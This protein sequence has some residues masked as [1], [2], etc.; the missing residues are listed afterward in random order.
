MDLFLGCFGDRGQGR[1]REPVI[2]GRGKRVFTLLELLIVIAII[3]VLAAMLLPALSLAREKGRQTVCLGNLRQIGSAC[4]LYEQ[5]FEAYYGHDL[6]MTPEGAVTAFHLVRDFL[7]D[8]GVMQCPSNEAE[9][10]TAGL[11]TAFKVPMAPGF[12]AS[13]YIFNT[14]VW[15]TGNI[16]DPPYGERNIRTTELKFP[17]QTMLFGG[18][19]VKPPPD[20]RTPVMANHARYL[21]TV[22]CDGHTGVFRCREEGTTYADCENEVHSDWIIRNGYYVGKTDFRGIVTENGW[23]DSLRP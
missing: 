4:S 6:S 21:N 12:V 11:E 2:M 7:A 1:N 23:V 3:A 10:T 17:G 8:D 13:S 5:S 15:E 22:F 18:G 19:N 14:A 16:M 20:A 9:I